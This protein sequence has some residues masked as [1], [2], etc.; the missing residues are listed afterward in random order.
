MHGRGAANVN[1]SLI[2]SIISDPSHPQFSLEL[3]R[4]PSKVT[5]L[6]C[7]QVFGILTR[8]FQTQVSE[9]S[10]ASI[11]ACLYQLISNPDFAPF[12]TFG[13][14]AD[15]IPFNNGAYGDP[16]FDLLYVIAQS[17]PAAM[18]PTVARRF[19]RLISFNPA[20]ALT[21]V[22]IFATQDVENPWPIVDLLLR[23][24][25][26][27]FFGDDCLQDYIALLVHLCRK[28]PSFRVERGRLVWRRVCTILASQIE[29][30]DSIYWAL[31]SLAECVPDVAARA[32]P[33]SSVAR[34]LGRKSVLS[35]LL[36]VRPTTDFE[37]IVGDLIA[38]A[39][40]Q[41]DPNNVTAAMI[42]W[43]FAS[44]FRVAEWLVGHSSWMRRPLPTVANTLTLFAIL[45]R[46]APLREQ[47]AQCEDTAGFLGDLAAA[48]DS[49]GFLMATVKLIRRLPITP[50]FV[51]RLSTSGTLTAF[52]TALGEVSGQE[53]LRSA[54][55][56]YDTIGKVAYA[57]DY[58]DACEFIMKMVKRRTDDPALPI[59]AV[60]V[61]ATLC[62][63]PECAAK[64]RALKLHSLLAQAHAPPAMQKA[65]A[66]FMR[67]FESAGN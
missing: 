52:Y 48:E 39:G 51:A 18:T 17:C 24:V 64:F 66:R 41:T 56:L 11:L 6:Q 53:T 19:S 13:N 55:L 14:F 29:D 8:H 22:A 63:W 57:P 23:P 36:R 31:C 15:L 27:N 54:M 32:F 9:Q 60:N 5:R 45:M 65:A 1:G 59:V 33:T 34:E 20:K 61:A 35:L 28:D 43:E 25:S 47:I 49:N 37:G 40:K 10:A 3:G 12:F 42:L 58:G 7:N 4:L 50:D 67:Q 21:I 2:E 30:P 62:A 26:D 46:H 44:I 16:L 38:M